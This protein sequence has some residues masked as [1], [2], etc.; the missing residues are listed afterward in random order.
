MLRRTRDLMMQPVAARW[1]RNSSFSEP[2][3]KFLE[4]QDPRDTEK[5]QNGERNKT[6]EQKS[7]WI[8]V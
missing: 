1:W 3:P 7:A 5:Q 6:L 4:A 8:V 2:G